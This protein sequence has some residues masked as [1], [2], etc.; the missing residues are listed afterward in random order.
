MHVV[1]VPPAPFLSPGGRLRVVALPAAT[2]NLVWAL[3]C[4]ATGAVA[5]VDG[6]DA[7]AA[8]QHLR[9]AHGG[10]VADGLFTTHTHGDHIGLHRAWVASG[11]LPPSVVGAAST[12]AAI[13]GLTR[14]VT[15]GDRV[16]VGAVE[17]EVLA[18][19][20][21]VDGHVAY[22]FDGALFCG[23]TL[24][25]AGCGAL[26]DGPPAAMFRSLMRLAALPAETRVCCAHEYTLDNLRFAWFVEPDNAALAARARDAVARRAAGETVVPSTIA[27]ERATNPFLRPGSPSIRAAIA[28]ELPDAPLETAEQAF[29][30]TRRLKDLRRHVA[31]AL[32][33]Q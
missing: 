32:P 16:A 10:R 33:G 24:F 23:D 2:D 25:A 5:F 21:H 17:G 1:R 18:V 12:A 26:F 14:G 28:R 3:T 15:D 30:A 22:C 31:V 29:A 19:P 6:P 9:E 27:L 13:P 4:V 7:V 8:D 11:R 20:G